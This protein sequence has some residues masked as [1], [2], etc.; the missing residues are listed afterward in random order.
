MF[1]FGPLT[2]NY[3]LTEHGQNEKVYINEIHKNSHVEEEGKSSHYILEEI[4]RLREE[5]AYLSSLIKSL[6]P[7]SNSETLYKKKPTPSPI[8]IQ[9]SQQ[10][11]IV[12]KL[13]ENKN[14]SKFIIPIFKAEEEND[15]PKLDQIYQDSFLTK[16]KLYGLDLL[17]NSPLTDSSWKFKSSRFRRS[18]QGSHEENLILKRP[19]VF[20]QIDGTTRVKTSLNPVSASPL[21]TNSEPSTFYQVP[22]PSPDGQESFIQLPPET[23]GT[24]FYESNEEVDVSLH[25]SFVIQELQQQVIYNSYRYSMES[26]I[27]SLAFGQGTTNL[28]SQTETEGNTLPLMPK[29]PALTVSDITSAVIPESLPALTVSLPSSSSSSDALTGPSAVI[30]AFGLSLIPTL[31]VSIPFFL[32]RGRALVNSNNRTSSQAKYDHNLDYL[33]K[34]YSEH[35]VG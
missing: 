16:P 13:R 27:T 4:S 19:S 26:N 34:I 21:I 35:V 7:Q 29:P 10:R 25:P 28:N 22:P 9:I 18:L 23:A 24:S 5:N 6:V 30:V 2:S 31:A 1:G 3:G 32:R 17:K 12:L 11:P 8:A 20:N 15:Y 14:N 33:E